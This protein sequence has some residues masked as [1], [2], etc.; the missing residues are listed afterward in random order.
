MISFKVVTAFA[1]DLKVDFDLVTESIRVHNEA[2]VDRV[3]DNSD[4]EEVVLFE[5]IFSKKIPS[6]SSFR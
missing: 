5:L 6:F 2:D 1:L 4:S 3:N